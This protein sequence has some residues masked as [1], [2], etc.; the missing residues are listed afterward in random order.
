MADAS[1]DPDKQP[2]RRSR[3]LVLVMLGIIVLSIV[4]FLTL[5]PDPSGAGH[6]DP[7]S[8]H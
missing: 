1:L 4:A 6:T 5:R 7:T 2:G 8:Q 3:M